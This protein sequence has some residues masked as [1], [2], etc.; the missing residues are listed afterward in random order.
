MNNLV[1]AL[2][3]EPT[4][5]LYAGGHFS[6]VGDGSKPTV[7]FAIYD[8]AAVSATAPAAARAALRLFP[9]P[10][11]G[12]VTLALAPAATARAGQVLDALAGRCAPSRCRRAP[13]AS[14]WAWPGCRPA[15]TP[16]GWAR[17]APVCCWS[18]GGG[19]TQSKHAIMAV[20][21]GRLAPKTGRRVCL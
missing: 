15:P 18:S 7:R 3:V 8:P 17:P 12:P 14:P 19:G 10:A 4:N 16:C 2:A 6:G 21:P 20:K 13:K 5:S 1:S 11:H 9:D